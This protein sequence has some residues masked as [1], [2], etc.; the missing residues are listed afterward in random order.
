MEMTGAA[1]KTGHLI[2][3]C[4]TLIRL[5]YLQ[6]YQSQWISSCPVF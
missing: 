3:R 2:G 1:R 4:P 5:Q 6:Q